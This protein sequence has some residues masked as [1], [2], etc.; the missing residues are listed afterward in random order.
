M[1]RQIEADP[2]VPLT[3]SGHGEDLAI[4][5]FMPDI[6]VFFS[7]Q[8][9]SNTGTLLANYRLLNMLLVNVL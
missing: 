6:S 9:W 2:V 8:A 7:R 3:G 4:H 1:K 5:I